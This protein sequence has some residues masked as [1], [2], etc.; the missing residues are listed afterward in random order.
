MPILSVRIA[1][2]GLLTVLFAVPAAAQRIYMPSGPSDGYGGPSS[3]RVP[4]RTPDRYPEPRRPRPQG[5]PGGGYPGPGIG[6]IVAP[7]IYDAP[8]PRVIYEDDEPAPSRPARKPATQKPK[9]KPTVAKKPPPS[10]PPPAKPAT[11]ARP[12]APPPP[13]RNAAAP[14]YVPDEVVFEL[15]PDISEAEIAGVLRRFALTPLARYGL[16]LL[17]TSIQHARI[18]RGS[19]VPTVVRQL[20][21][22]PRVASA[23]PNFVFDGQADEA[24]TAATQPELAGAQYAPDRMKIPEAHRLAE[25][26]DVLVAVIDSAVDPAHPELADALIERDTKAKPHTHGTGMA[27]A[28]AAHV[29]LV[30]IAPEARLLALD[31][32]RYDTSGAAKGTTIDIVTALDTAGKR[33]ARVVNL[34]FAGPRDELMARALR[35]LRLRGAVL[36]A[37]A[38]NEGPKAKPLFPAAHPDVIAVTAT[39]PDDALYAQANIGVQIAIAAPGVEVMVPAPGG[40][41]QVLSGTSLASA[42]VSGVAALMLQGHPELTP[43]QV[44][45]A[46]VRTARDLGKLGRDDL[47][48]AGLIDAAAA[49]AA[50]SEAASATPAAASPEAAAIR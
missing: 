19:Q 17:G 13:V 33:G 42:H 28:I 3:G 30:G 15:K 24:A 41:Y 21:A 45:E 29:K 38:G 36:V 47:Y 4:D 11:T 37:A 40:A 46:L 25:G 14:D 32:L 34:S 9:Q 35:A 49:V 31:A 16:E 43:A 18:P 20:A 10:S 50:A 39:G 5:Y 12:V 2:Y 1:A 48:G 44:R 26:K 22:D 6:I 23:Q 27:G 8:P 7:P